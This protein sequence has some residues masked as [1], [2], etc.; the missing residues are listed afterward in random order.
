MSPLFSCFTFILLTTS[1]FTIIKLV[2]GW[3]SM[4][5]IIDANSMTKF[6]HSEYTF[7]CNSCCHDLD[8]NHVYDSMFRHAYSSHNEYKNEYSQ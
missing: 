5:S 3:E 6:F 8:G 1:F 2:V 7:S 4:L